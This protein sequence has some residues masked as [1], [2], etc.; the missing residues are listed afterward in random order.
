MATSDWL[1]LRLPATAGE[2]PARA[3]VDSSGALL[4]VP[5]DDGDLATLATGRQ[6]ALVAPAADVALFSVALPA[7]NEARLQQLAPFALEEQVSEDLDELHFAVGARDGAGQVAV[8]VAS[9]E[10]M[11]YWLAQAAALGVKPKA[12]FAESDLAPLLPGH[13]TMLLAPDTLV[14]RND[15]GRPVSFPADDPELA[16]TMV[17]GPGADLGTVNL[18]V[19][20]AP[21]DWPHFEAATEALRDRVASL[22]VQL[23]TSGLT[24]LYAQ[25]LSGSA[26]VNLLQGEFRPQNQGAGMWRQWRVAAA[27][28]GGLLLLHVAATLWDLRIA[29]QE[30]RALDAEISR[31]YG[32]IF[33]GQQPGPQ[34]RRTLEAHMK[35]AA[36]GGSAQGQLMPL[37]AALAAARQNVPV[38]TLDA[39]TFKPGMLQITLSAPEASA[40]EQFSQALQAGGYGATVASGS[41]T[42]RGFKG[43]I[44]MKVAGT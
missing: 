26:P 13:V 19:Y 21:E 24:G 15:G 41:P 18:S 35:A 14:L 23:F 4:P 31:V 29:R 7:G 2:S 28:L 43:Q 20:A 16:L 11:Q 33:P 30:A 25:G 12:L 38:A 37:L 42:E 22:K 36:G 9:R 34:L 40:L 27:L 5:A 17:L 44:E 39:M 8:A 3:L 1:L 10:R 32:T 6:V